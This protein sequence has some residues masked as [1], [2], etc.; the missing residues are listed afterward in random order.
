MSEF[1]VS[2]VVLND[3]ETLAIE[4]FKER[5]GIDEVYISQITPLVGER[6]TICAYEFRGEGYQVYPECPR[7]K[8]GDIVRCADVSNNE[9]ILG[10]IYQVVERRG[11]GFCVFNKG[12]PYACCSSSFEKYRGVL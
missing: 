4:R 1:K 7:F 8:A 11:V 5:Y 10:N 9:L 6:I 3:D 12:E 2:D